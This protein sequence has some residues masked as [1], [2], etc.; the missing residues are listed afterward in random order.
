M[1]LVALLPMVNAVVWPVVPLLLKRMESIFTAPVLLVLVEFV[2]VPENTSENVPDVV[3]DVVQLPDVFHLTLAPVPDQVVIV[4]ADAVLAAARPMRA[5]KAT[6]SAVVREKRGMARGDSGGMWRRGDGQP[7]QT[8]QPDTKRVKFLVSDFPGFKN[9]P[10]KRHKVRLSGGQPPA[11]ARRAR[12][13]S[14]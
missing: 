9:F 14:D 10:T 5:Y 8:I 3:G 1:L 12:R 2:G 6:R 11:L 13:A 4:P 7:A